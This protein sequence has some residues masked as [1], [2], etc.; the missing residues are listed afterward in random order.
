MKIIIYGLGSKSK[1]IESKLK[2]TH[3]IIGY[4]DNNSNI[5]S[6]NNF[7]F[8]KLEELNSVEYDYIILAIDNAKACKVITKYLIA[9]YK[10]DSSKIVD[11]YHLYNNGVST[12][13]V[14]RVM[15]KS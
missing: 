4:T 6:F 7:R 15:Q 8:Y 5:Q 14:D 12:Q 10:I 1:F 3:K 13:K 11:F 9:K 2:D